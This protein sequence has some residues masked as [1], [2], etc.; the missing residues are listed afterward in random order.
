MNGIE[1]LIAVMFL[2]NGI[3]FAM[4]GIDKRNARA[5]SF[6]VPETRL[7]GLALIGPFGAF[8]G[9]LFFRHKTR[10]VKFLLVP[11]FLIIHAAVIALFV[12]LP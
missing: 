9:M 7:L 11:G 2:A 5:N 1:F 10:K 6:R 12:V 8:G 4:F 3:A